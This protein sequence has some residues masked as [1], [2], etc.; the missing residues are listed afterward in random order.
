MRDLRPAHDELRRLLQP[1]RGRRVDQLLGRLRGHRARRRRRSSA[2]RSTTRTCTSWT[3]TWPTSAASGS[4]L[5]LLRDERPELEVRELD[6]IVAERAGLAPDDD[7][8]RRLRGET[9][10]AARMSTARRSTPCPRPGG[11]GPPKPASHRAS[12]RAGCRSRRAGRDRRARRGHRADVPGTAAD[13]D[14]RRAGRRV[15]PPSVTAPPF[16]LPTELAIDTDVARRVIAEFIRGQLRQ[17]GFERAV[18]GLSGGIDSALVAYLVAEAIG[19]ERLLCV[20]MPYRTSSPAS[21]ADAETVVGRLGC[22]SELVDISPMV[23]GYF[24]RRRRARRRPGRWARG[25][26]APAGQPHGPDADGGPLRPLGD[27]ARPRGR[28]RQQDRVAHRLHDPLRRHRLRLQPDRRPLQEPGPPAR[29][30]DRRARGDHRARRRR[31]TCGRARRTRRRP[32]SATRSSTGS[33]SGWS[34]SGARPRSS[35][36]RG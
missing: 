29:G 18:L 28:D 23:D 3:S 31:P 7:G 34:T 9:A 13:A 4:R 5:P 16:D 12:E 25:E 19:A 11:H 24:G 32:A 1:G 6:R 2:R 21:R 10:T 17:A 14:G 27:L 30:R 20:L 8:D 35:R 15:R 26:P 22:A 33:S 36:R